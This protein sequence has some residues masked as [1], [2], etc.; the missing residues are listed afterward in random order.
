MNKQ[1]SLDEACNKL[2]L[3]KI[4]D[5]VK[6][7]A[8]TINKPEISSDQALKTLALVTERQWGAEYVI[9][10]YNATCKCW[11]FFLIT[12]YNISGTISTH[13]TPRKTPILRN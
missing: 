5:I 4:I 8:C 11:Q 1:L 12:I 13:R 3:A 7:K 9:K 6:E 2:I 10:I